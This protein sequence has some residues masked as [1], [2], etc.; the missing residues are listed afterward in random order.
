MTRTTMILL[1][2]T[3]SLASCSTMQEADSGP[4]AGSE[5]RLVS[6]TSMDDAQGV[7][8]PSEDQTL[9]IA[10][11]SDGRAAMQ[12]DCNRGT[13]S[14]QAMATGNNSGTISFGPV[15][16]TRALCPK[17][18]LGELMARQLPYVASYMMADGK[19][20]LALKMDGGIF[21]FEQ[22]N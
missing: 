4:L 12:L 13:A 8:L 6:F 9:T 21:E 5:W 18:Q 7:S 20:A 1:V 11:G 15:A 16:A 2:A 3:L 17:P 19:L 22:V 10:F 14:Y